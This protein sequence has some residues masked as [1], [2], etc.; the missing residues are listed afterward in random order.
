MK[1]GYVIAMTLLVCQF[2][3]GQ[4]KY[5]YNSIGKL[6]YVISDTLKHKQ[7]IIGDVFVESVKTSTG[8]YAGY[9]TNKS[10]VV[11]GNT[12]RY[13]RTTHEPYVFGC[14]ISKKSLKSLIAWLRHVNENYERQDSSTRY[15]FLDESLALDISILLPANYN[16][17][18]LVCD[19]K[20]YRFESIIDKLIAN[21]QELNSI[22]ENKHNE[23]NL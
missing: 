16:W 13:V 14:T 9:Y 23:Y 7:Q 1:K 11:T 15:A 17:W 20:E 8:T 22:L 6:N 12:F 10:Y 18:I 5:V 4:D 2:A 21:L 3:I 19:G